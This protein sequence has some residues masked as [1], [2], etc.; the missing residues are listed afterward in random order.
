MPPR[1][2]ACSTDQ[3]NPSPWFSTKRWNIITVARRLIDDEFRV[4][5][6]FRDVIELGGQAGKI[7]DAVII[8]VEKR[9][10]M[11]LIDDG[12]LV[13]QRIVRQRNWEWACAPRRDRAGYSCATSSWRRRMPNGADALF[14]RS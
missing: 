13:P 10:D 11:M 7:A 8:G 4:A 2:L 3:V 5:P 9:F 1:R 6:Q 12:I 14:T